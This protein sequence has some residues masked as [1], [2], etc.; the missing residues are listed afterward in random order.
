[1]HGSVR[2]LQRR[3]DAESIA[4]IH[5]AL[6]LGVT[7]LDTAD[8]HGFGTNEEL[9]GKAIHGR[10]AEVFLATKFSIVRSAATLRPY[11]LMADPS[12]C[13]RHATPA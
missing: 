2:V 11:G 10:R 7:F 12:T 5:R 13:G 1:L 6:E 3:D 4:T 8:T 9:V